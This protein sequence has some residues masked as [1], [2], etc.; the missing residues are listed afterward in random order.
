MGIPTATGTAILAI[1]DADI[2]RFLSIQTGG[3]AVRLN[4]YLM[5]GSSSNKMRFAAP[6]RAPTD[7]PVTKRTP[8]ESARPYWFVHGEAR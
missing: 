7:M 6:S 3:A 2:G 4:H 8:M 5:S 1:M